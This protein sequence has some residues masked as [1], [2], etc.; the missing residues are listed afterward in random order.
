MTSR[1]FLIFS[2]GVALLAGPGVASAQSLTDVTAHATIG[3]EPVLDGSAEDNRSGTSIESS[4]ASEALAAAQE[5]PPADNRPPGCPGCPP[6]RVGSSLLW[7]TAVNG[8]YELA[9]LIRGQDT[10]KITPETWW[11]NM[12]RGWEWDLDDFAVNQIGHP[13]QGNNYFTTG[14]ANG[15]NF[16]ESA[17]LTA[18]GSGTW[19]YFGETNQASL[20]DFINTTLGGIALGEMFHRTAWLV[21]NTQATGRSRMWNEIGAMALDPMSGL[22]R[23]MSGDAS[24]VV[25]K[26]AEMVPDSLSTVMSF[27]TLWRGSNT[28]AVE[29]DTYGFF[30]TDLLYGD[31]ISGASRVPYDAFAVRLSFGGGSGFSEARVRGRLFS[32]PLG[33][34]M[35]TIAQR[36]QFNNNPAYRFGAQAFEASFIRERRF[37]PRT[38]MVVLGG[39]GLTVLGAVDSIPLE[40]ITPEPEPPPDAGQGVS[41]GPRFY[42]YGPGGNLT[43]NFLLRRDNR[44]ILGATWELYHLHVLD[45]VRA[46]HMLQRAR[47]DFTW[48]LRGA[49]GIGG[50]YEFFSR[51]T[52]YENDAGKATYHFPQYRVFLTWT[53]S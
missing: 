46:N 21:R 10:A 2:L 41:T 24:R 39:G 49:L 43:A 15:L 51:N 23:F 5:P 45:G 50:S 40:G 47:V 4:A 36:Y 34:T 38:S 53:A 35:F 42:D 19:E 17:G 13:Y 12:K 44:N 7:V 3:E 20:N 22:M 9:N 48:P 30:E 26:P 11:I 29:S 6:R 52:Y 16:W 31:I 28:E 1:P 37:T 8:V 27:G 25:E 14:R 18:F 32:T 33:G